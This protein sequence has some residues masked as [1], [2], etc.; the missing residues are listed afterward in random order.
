MNW[1]AHCLLSEPSAEF[2]IGNLL[3]DLVGREELK[4]LP[5][6]YTAGIECHRRI[7]QF[8]DSHPVVRRSINRLRSEHRRFGGIA[9]DLFYDHFL[10]VDW[11]RH[12]PAPLDT[13][14]RETYASFE[15]HRADLPAEAFDVL[16]RMAAE[17]WLG[18]YRTMDGLRLAL[19]RIG[20]RLR[21]PTDLS[22]CVG[23]LDTQYEAFQADF[24]EFFPQLVTHVA[25]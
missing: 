8:T 20:A 23:N 9:I 10:A 25:R 4:Q 1:L 22:V 19:K 13:F 17:D 6:I 15:S 21:R 18:S 5:S 3:P 7:D 2:R 16:Q 12:C 11:H 24:T 14:L